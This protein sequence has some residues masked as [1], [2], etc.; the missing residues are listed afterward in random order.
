MASLVESQNN[1]TFLDCFSCSIEQDY[2]N[3]RKESDEQNLFLHRNEKELNDSLIQSNEP[4]MFYSMMSDDNFTEFQFDEEELN[5]SEMY[6][7]IIEQPCLSFREIFTQDVLKELK[8]TKNNKDKLLEKPEIGIKSLNITIVFT[9]PENKENFIQHKEVINGVASES[10]FRKPFGWLS[11]TIISYNGDGIYEKKEDTYIHMFFKKKVG[12]YH[13]LRQILGG[14]D[15]INGIIVGAEK[16][17]EEP[18][19]H[20][21]LI[22]KFSTQVSLSFLDNQKLEY[23]VN[24]DIENPQ[25]CY[26]Q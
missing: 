3:S 15:R 5:Q 21:K 1:S 19:P 17:N 4:E 14:Q 8:Q 25:Y 12:T 18:N 9:D 13:C 2:L 11:E 26:H 20:S 16:E 23:T 6:H 10:F 22:S 24:F 7:S